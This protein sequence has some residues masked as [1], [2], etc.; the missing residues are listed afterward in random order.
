LQHQIDWFVAQN[1]LKPGIKI[2]DMLDKRVVVALPE[3]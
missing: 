1:M 3:R 2:G